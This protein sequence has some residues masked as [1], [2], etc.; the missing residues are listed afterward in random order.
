MAASDLEISCRCGEFTAVLKNASPKSGSHVQ[1]YC[2]DCQA[3]AHALG[4]ADVLM[5]RG[6]TDVFQTTP[7]NLHIT[8]GQDHLACLRLSPR[9]L[10]RWHTSCCDTPVFNTLGTTKVAFL[11]VMVPALK[12]KA[13]ARAVGP[14]IA[15]ANTLYASVG[16]P[17]GPVALRD[18][19]IN[20]AGFNIIARHIAA[21][22]R[23]EAKKGPLS[24]ATGQPIVTPRV[25]RQ[26]ER[27]AC[28]P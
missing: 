20:R 6:G 21:L 24:D 3:G 2:K 7:A 9:G 4:A 11:G 16:A 1:C 22:L 18:Y 8:K 19:G 27:R 5:A 26:A 14:V 12:D 10:M 13:A 25:L 15:V 23:G 17:G 28:T